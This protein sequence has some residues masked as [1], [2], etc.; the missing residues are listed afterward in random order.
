MSSFSG[1]P[2]DANKAEEE[3][4]TPRPG[5]AIDFICGDRELGFCATQTGHRHSLGT[6]CARRH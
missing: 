6:N 1:E 5:E 3:M 4:E 2:A